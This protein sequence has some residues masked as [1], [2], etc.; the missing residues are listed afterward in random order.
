[1]PRA[2]WSR[3]ARNYWTAKRCVYQRTR[4]VAFIM[5]V[6]PSAAVVAS[7]PELTLPNRLPAV[8]VEVP[9]ITFFRSTVVLIP[10]AQLY[11]SNGFWKSRLNW[12]FRRSLIVN[13]L[14]AAKLAPIG[15]I[16]QAVD[17]RILITLIEAVATQVLPGRRESG[18]TRQIRASAQLMGLPLQASQVQLSV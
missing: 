1:M 9:A 4:M 6:P 10:V 3:S 17:R 14:Y 5:G 2:L 15:E 11:H 7:L 13:S 8:S 16:R 18:R 12:S